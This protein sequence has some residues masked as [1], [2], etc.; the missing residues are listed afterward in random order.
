MKAGLVVLLLALAPGLLSAQERVLAGQVTDSAGVAI[1]MARIE[2]VG[3]GR[4]VTADRGGRWMLRLPG[5]G[6]ASVAIEVTHVG[7]ARRRSNINVAG[8]TTQVVTILERLPVTLG[9]VQVTATPVGREPLAVSQSTTTMQGRELERNAAATLGATLG[10][11]AGISVRSQGPAASAP[12]IRGMSGDRVLVLQDGVRT[13]DLSGT[14][15]DHAI[16]VDPSSAS[17]IEIVRGPAALLYGNNAVGGVVNVISDDIPGWI[18]ER[19]SGAAGVNAESGAPGGALTLEQLIP[20]GGGA[21]RLRAGA[22]LHGDVAT[23]GGGL[24]RRL[25]NTG[26]R[27]EFGSAGIGFPGSRGTIGAAVRGYRFRYGLPVPLGS[28]EDAITLEGDRYELV[29]RA[30]RELDAGPFSSFRVDGSAQS[31]RHDELLADGALGTRLAAR[32]FAAGASVRA[33]E[34]LRL[35]DAA[36]GASAYHRSNGVSGDQALT[37]ANDAS[38]IGA[39]AFE[40]ILLG[41][42]RVPMGVRVDR[43]SISTR[44]TPRFGAARARTF[45]G[46]SG[47]IGAV[48]PV[49]PGASV[50]LTAAR[51]VRSPTAE[52]LFSEAGHAGTGAYE[53]GDPGLS[54]EMTTGLDAILRLERSRMA[55]QVAGYFTGV[56]GFIGLYPAGRDTIIPDGSGGSKSLPLYMISQRRASFRGL[57]GSLDAALPSH[58]VLRLMADAVIARDSEGEPLPFIPAARAGAGLRYDD[59]RISGGLD[60]RRTFRQGDVPDG[61]MR[62]GA[63]TLVVLHAGVRLVAAGH[64]HVVTARLDNATNVLYHDASSRVKEFAPNPGRSLTVGYRIAY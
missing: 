22:R 45:T 47:S 25:A 42:V 32:T 40:E 52:E 20:A 18:P 63:F 21:L 23:G 12:V 64:V 11:Q 13:G 36:F 58:L 26:A 29:A 6:A 56:D 3:A 53:I 31:Y 19:R 38:G 8:D 48:L 5:D 61:E 14:A 46:V 17:R 28:P 9:E 49:A 7:Y 59:N 27:S 10:S 37:P 62:T 33:G 2:I 41:N 55:L 30:E 57:D 43:F 50:A 4:T 35:R 44:A 60:V 51:A 16:T 1:P 39:Y 24:S 34:R 15:P 54:T